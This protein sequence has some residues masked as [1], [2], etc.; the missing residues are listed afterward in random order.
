MVALVVSA[1]ASAPWRMTSLTAP[2]PREILEAAILPAPWLLIMSAV[3]FGAIAA[4]AACSGSAAMWMVC[5][6]KARSR[7]GDVI[8][9]LSIQLNFRCRGS[10]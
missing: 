6:R 7:K 4:A 3:L 9:D 1:S 5:G 2:V 10:P 8:Y